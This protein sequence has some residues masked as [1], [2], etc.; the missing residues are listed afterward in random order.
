MLGAL[1]EHEAAG[2]ACLATAHP[3]IAAE[4]AALEEALTGLADAAATPPPA[5]LQDQIWAS[6]QAAQR[7]TE[8]AHI[9]GEYEAKPAEEA[10]PRRQS[11][12]ISPRR[13]PAF[14]WAQAAMLVGLVA[15]G[16]LAFYQRNAQQQV[17]QSRD[18][19]VEKLNQTQDELGLRN[20]QLAAYQQEHTMMLS[21]NMN[22][23]MMRGTR[24]G[25]DMG[26]MVF[27]DKQKSEA[28]VSMAGMPAPPTGKQYQLWAIT[29]GK[30]VSLG[31]VP[32]ANAGK[33]TPEKVAVAV[34]AGEAFAVSLE[35]MGGV[36]SPTADMIFVVGAV[37][38]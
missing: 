13:Q 30:P 22:M 33:P 14:A 2:V 7:G 21:P 28:Y 35:N 27:W 25:H 15:L 4:I 36:A 6:I 20:E 34:P 26:G 24:E 3:E 37:H 29:G 32:V 16:A 19:A 1:P 8:A 9:N 12:D 11:I 10:A 18:E 31:V 17:V 38:G 5:G 23:V